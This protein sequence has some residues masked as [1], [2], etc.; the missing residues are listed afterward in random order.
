MGTGKI[1][2]DVLFITSSV[3]THLFRVGMRVN[4]NLNNT[5]VFT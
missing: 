2:S 5:N 3:K 4:R 1:Y